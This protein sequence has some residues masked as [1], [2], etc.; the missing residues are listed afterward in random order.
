MSLVLDASVAIA[1]C[2][3]DET[4]VGT[5]RV[6]DLV[7]DL[8]ALVPQIFRLEVSNVLLMAVRRGRIS[9]EGVVVHLGLLD[10]LSLLVDVDTSTRAWPETFELATRERLTTYDAS[11]LEL[12]LR[13]GSDVATLDTDLIAAAR[14]RGVTVLP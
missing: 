10:D 4:T 8:G 3:D 1:W 14:R 9:L 7:Q 6:A 11:Y 13:T 12:A 2:F 5:E